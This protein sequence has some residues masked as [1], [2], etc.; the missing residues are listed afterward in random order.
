MIQGDIWSAIL[1]LLVAVGS[2]LG[3]VFMGSMNGVRG[4]RLK[5][6]TVEEVCMDLEKWADKKPILAPY[7]E[8]VKLTEEKQE[9]QLSFLPEKDKTPDQV[10]S[11]IFSNSNLRK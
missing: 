1:K 2:L 10:A 6:S 7:Q 8:P 5:L 4:A 11:S 3:A 9:T